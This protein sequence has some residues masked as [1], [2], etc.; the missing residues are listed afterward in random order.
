MF[1]YTYG[2]ARIGGDSAVL[3][4]NFLTNSNLGLINGSGGVA[5]LAP[6]LDN[7]YQSFAGGVLRKTDKGLIVEDTRQNFIAASSD[8]I[9]AAWAAG[10]FTGIVSK[11][12]VIPSVT[13]ASEFESNTNQ[14]LINQN[15]RGTFSA[16]V[17]TLWCLVEAT[18]SA[19][20]FGMAMGDS[21]SGNVE[22]IGMYFNF[23]T[24][25]ITQRGNAN[26]RIFGYI[27]FG[28][29]SGPNGGNLFLLITSGT[30]AAG[31]VGHT[32]RMFLYPNGSTAG[33]AGRK[34]TLHHLQYEP[35]AFATSPIVNASTTSNTRAA[36][37]ITVSV[38]TG[39]Y[40]VRFTTQDGTINDKYAVASSSNLLTIPLDIT[41][42]VSIQIGDVFLQRLQR[43]GSISNI[44]IWNQ[45][46]NNIHG[47]GDSYLVLGAS[48][49]QNVIQWLPPK[50]YRPRVWTFDGVGATSLT[51]QAV[52][53]D[54]TPSFYGDLLVI[55][56]GVIDGLT[57]N[58]DFALIVQPAIESM[59]AHLTTSPKQWIY[60]QPNPDVNAGTVGSVYYTRWLLIQSQIKAAYP[61]NYVETLPQ[62]QAFNNGSANDLADIAAGEWPRSLRID[63]ANVHPNE[64]GSMY[65]AQ[66][67]DN[68]IQARGY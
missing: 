67:I 13:G 11:L 44:S 5:G 58:N 64:L 59:L 2:K 21:T 9:N 41:Q 48:G 19:T 56:D 4:V 68:A 63:A 10:S 27:D 60:V 33:T 30:P 1:P 53:F 62:M 52:R 35:G 26:T 22:V 49:G 51:Q 16:G 66:I 38:A 18:P 61:N 20:D 14:G 12:S 34:T 54:A 17:E 50:L 6:K 46:V 65:L 28:P 25:V 39:T 24:K 42:N 57:T 47:L 29:A 8:F 3:G 43:N 15:N 36:E 23:V 32:R 7:T 45:K 31:T 55:V 40:D 37:S